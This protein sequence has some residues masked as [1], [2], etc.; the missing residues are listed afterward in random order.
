MTI[1]TDFPVIF[2][3]KFS[4]TIKDKYVEKVKKPPGNFCLTNG[5]RLRVHH[6]VIVHA[7]GC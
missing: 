1:H 5:K 7:G 2:P 3:P 4:V 6:W